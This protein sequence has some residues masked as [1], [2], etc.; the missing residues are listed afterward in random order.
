M[1]K[2]IFTSDDEKRVKALLTSDKVF[3]Q[4]D[5]IYGLSDL[6][7]IPSLFV[8]GLVVL[9]LDHIRFGIKGH[10]LD[11]RSLGSLEVEL[12]LAKISTDQRYKKRNGGDQQREK[13]EN[14]SFWSQRLHQISRGELP[15]DPMALGFLGPTLIRKQD[16][17]K[18][19]CLNAAC[20]FVQVSCKVVFGAYIDP[21]SQ[22]DGKQYE[23]YMSIMKSPDSRWWLMYPNEAVG[24]WPVDIFKE[25]GDYARHTNFGGKIYNS[26]PGSIH[27]STQ[28]RSGHFPSE[29]FGRACFIRNIRYL[30][31]NR[32]FVSPDPKEF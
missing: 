20:G 5:F 7:K 25:F 17:Y 28:M 24:Y 4:G 12:G 9:G 21:I 8:Y 10:V 22:Y 2:N 18:T 27:T 30:N 32:T 13:E 14:V 31:N 6:S 16:G 3:G 19:G 11:R 26:E 29:G 23:S 15:L 1:E